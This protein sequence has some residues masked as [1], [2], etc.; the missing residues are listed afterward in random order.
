M[1]FTIYTFINIHIL[2]LQF[3]YQFISHLSIFSNVFQNHID[4]HPIRVHL[5]YIYDKLGRLS[6]Q[7]VISKAFC[8]VFY[9]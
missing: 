4:Y 5:I 3:R 2:S 1:Y 7:G 9:F 8:T 6:P